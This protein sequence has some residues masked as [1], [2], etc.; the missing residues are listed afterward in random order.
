METRVSG[1]WFVSSMDV[2]EAFLRALERYGFGIMLATAVLWFV[3]TDLVLPMVDAHRAFLHEMATTQRDISRAIQEQTR[4]LYAL[5][6]QPPT[7]AHVDV[8]DRN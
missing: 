1:G 7:A 8:K 3:R 2:Y 4:L 5:Q 6:P